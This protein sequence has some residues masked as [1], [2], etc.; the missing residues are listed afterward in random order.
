MTPQQISVLF[1][2]DQNYPEESHFCKALK[3]QH[4]TI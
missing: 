4:T 3:I 1:F 2:G